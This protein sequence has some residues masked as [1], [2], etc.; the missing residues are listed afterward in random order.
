MGGVMEKAALLD[1]I[2]KEHKAL[3][4]L[5]YRL[6]GTEMTGPHVY[7]E[8]TVKDVIAHIA[9][10]EKMEVGWIEVS[11]RGEKVVRYATGFEAGDEWGEVGE[12]LNEHIFKENRDKPLA[13]V[14]ADYRHAHERILRVVERLSEED[15]NDPH[16][17][18]WWNGEPIWTSIAGNTYE[19]VREHRELIEEWLKGFRR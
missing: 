16:R 15:L 3:E 18:D 8:L 13:D 17:F 6:N 1:K 19:H 10:W 4:A 7:G 14:L 11:L 9:A 2:E 5:L 12:R